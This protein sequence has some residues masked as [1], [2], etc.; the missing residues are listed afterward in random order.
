MW[1]KLIQP[2]P[3]CEDI[4]ED[5]IELQVSDCLY[6]PEN[7]PIQKACLFSELLEYSKLETDAQGLPVK[8]IND[9]KS[10]DVPDSSILSEPLDIKK[11]RDDIIIYK[12]INLQVSS[13]IF[14]LCF[15]DSPGF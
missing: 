12:P 2:N 14:Y 10:L 1:K 11:I 9:V 4:H 3:Y 15:T 7:G 8:F 5:L 13:V 6:A